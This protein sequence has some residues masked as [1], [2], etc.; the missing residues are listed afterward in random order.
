MVH[1]SDSD[2]PGVVDWQAP[3][4]VTNPSAVTGSCQPPIAPTRHAAKSSHPMAN[5]ASVRAPYQV[6]QKW[7]TRLMLNQTLSLRVDSLVNST[8]LMPNTC[9]LGNNN[10]R[11]N[12]NGKHQ[13][14]QDGQLWKGFFLLGDLEDVKKCGKITWY[15]PGK[16]YLF[17]RWLTIIQWRWMADDG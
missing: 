12:N 15:P 3:A 6:Q 14:R 13:W 2:L 7:L 10:W 5:G 17:L 11:N 4:A 1:W 16:P 8:G 9:D